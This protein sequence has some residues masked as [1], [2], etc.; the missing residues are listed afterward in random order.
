MRSI[1]ALLLLSTT[2]ALAE[3]PAAIEGRVELKRRPTDGPVVVYVD[4][5]G[6]DFSTPLNGRVEQRNL[7][8][9]P[10][11]AVVSVDSVV[12][13]PNE[14]NVLHNVFSLTPGSEFDLQEYGAG[15]TRSWEPAQAGEVEIYCNRHE[16]MAMKIL[17]LPNAWYAQVEAD[18]SFKI[19]GV[20][21]GS[22]TLVAWSASHWEQRIDVSVP[23]EGAVQASFALKRR[24]ADIPHTNKF[25]LPYYR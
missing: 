12:D 14:D 23:E 17:V 1:L 16:D 10:G 19:E 4:G 6:P 25:G 2:P 5:E 13:F 3:G 24:P 15:R 8:F 11:S 21:P 9:A 22:H 20:S 7:A 18:G